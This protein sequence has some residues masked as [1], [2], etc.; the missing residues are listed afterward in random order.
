MIGRE[1]PSS[2]GGTR[3]SPTA[4]PNGSNRETANNYYEMGEEFCQ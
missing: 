2:I 3:V 1:L 4:S